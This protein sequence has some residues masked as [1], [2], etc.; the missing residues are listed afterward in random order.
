MPK[1]MIF[2]IYHNPVDCTNGGIS[3]N[4]DIGL[5]TGD[6]I[7]EIFD[8]GNLPVFKLVERKLFGEI[9]LHLEPLDND[10]RKWFMFGGNFGYSSDGRWPS[11]NAIK[12][13]DRTE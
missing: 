10:G 5:L 1:G 7:P 4:S 8:A 9:A 6:G 2:T 12:I 11:A 3:A 13:H